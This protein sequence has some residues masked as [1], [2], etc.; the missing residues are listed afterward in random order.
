[1][2]PAVSVGGTPGVPPHASRVGAA[3]SHRRR[4][5]DVQNPLEESKRRCGSAAELRLARVVVGLRG[6]SLLDHPRHGGEGTGGAEFGRG[7]LRL[8]T[9]GVGERDGARKAPVG[10]STGYG[11]S[12]ETLRGPAC[13][14]VGPRCFL[15]LAVLNDAYDACLLLTSHESI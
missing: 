8:A 6:Q 13:T 3:T 1:M 5:R 4:P 11:I 12:R 7:G 10:T 14:L 2:P 15:A 9:H